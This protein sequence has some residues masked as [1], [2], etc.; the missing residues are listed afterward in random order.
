MAFTD[1]SVTNISSVFRSLIACQKG[2]ENPI[3]SAFYP[4]LAPGFILGIEI[5]N[6]GGILIFAVELTPQN[7]GT[8][9]ND[10]PAGSQFQRLTGLGVASAPGSFAPHLELAEAADQDIFFIGQGIFDDFHELFHNLA[11]V[12]SGQFGL[13]KNSIY[14]PFF[15]DGH[16]PAPEV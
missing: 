5:I 4:T 14:D 12:F 7:P 3:L 2:L 15:G 13:L 6:E 8:V 11:G 16:V 10:H 1:V 9:E